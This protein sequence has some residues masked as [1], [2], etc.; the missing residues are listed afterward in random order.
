MESTLNLGTAQLQAE[1]YSADPSGDPITGG[2]VQTSYF[3][4]GEH[5]PYRKDFKVFDRVKPIE[6][7]FRVSTAD[8]VCMGRGAWELKAR[9]SWLDMTAG[10]TGTRGNESCFDAG[11]NWYWNPYTRMMFEY[12]HEDVNLLTGVD[13][14]N[15]NFGMRFQIDF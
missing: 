12:L 2:Y 13:G 15:D 11:V 9:Y 14:A 10:P 1:Y 7:F 8:G 5:R 4:T 6:D 3:L